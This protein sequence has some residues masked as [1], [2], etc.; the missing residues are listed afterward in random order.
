MA[1][2]IPTALLCIPGHHATEMWTERGALMQVARL[3]AMNGDLRPLRIIAPVPGAISSGVP[4]SPGVS[5][6][7][8]C[9]ATLRFSSAKVSAARRLFREG[10]YSIVHGLS[11]PMIKS[12]MS[13]PAI[14]PWVS[15]TQ[16]VRDTHILAAPRLVLVIGNRG[17]NAC[18][19]VVPVPS[20]RSLECPN[21]LWWANGE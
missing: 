1:R 10:S 14:V 18:D 4:T 9:V 8:Y 19:D 12:V 7:V 11:R 17:R 20:C 5:Q 21:F 13:I 16:N 3:I 15:P 2:A 6:L